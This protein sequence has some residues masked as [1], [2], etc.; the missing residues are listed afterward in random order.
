LPGAHYPNAT[1]STV[2]AKAENAR[3]K[4]DALTNRVGGLL[5]EPASH[6]TGRAGPHPAVPD[7]PSG[8]Q[9]LEKL[10][11]L[12]LLSTAT[13]KVTGAVTAV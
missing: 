12:P 9:R 4:L 10:L 11:R 7:E 8:K 5:A 2:T 1:S 13:A 6:T 3:A